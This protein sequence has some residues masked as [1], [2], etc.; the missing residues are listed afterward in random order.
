[1]LGKLSPSTYSAKSKSLGSR[2]GV[3]HPHSTFRNTWSCILFPSNLLLSWVEL[4]P[5]SSARSHLN[6]HLHLTCCV[7]CRWAVLFQKSTMP[8]QI[9]IENKTSIL[10]TAGVSLEMCSWLLV[11]FGSSVSRE[12]TTNNRFVFLNRKPRYSGRL[13]S[14]K[15]EVGRQNLRYTFKILTKL[16]EIE[17][18]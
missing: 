18:C 15:L 3:V 2:M 11:R 8:N 5:T 16:E 17:L 7:L 12:M 10:F 14:E 13:M 1:M 9:L 4:R 6:N